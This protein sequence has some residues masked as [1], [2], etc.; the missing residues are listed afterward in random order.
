MLKSALESKFT[1][2]QLFNPE[3]IS[4]GQRVTPPAPHVHRSLLAKLLP[5]VF[6]FDIAIAVCWIWAA[7]YHANWVGVDLKERQ[8]S[9]RL[10]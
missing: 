10:S 7:V 2:C 9:H 3:E 5:M 1:V 8:S 4:W 6:H